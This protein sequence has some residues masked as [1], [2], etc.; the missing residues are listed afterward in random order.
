MKTAA[1]FAKKKGKLNET[2]LE[3][4]GFSAIPSGRMSQQLH[5][6]HFHRGQL[7]EHLDVL[8]SV[9]KPQRRTGAVLMIQGSFDNFAAITTCH[10]TITVHI[11]QYALE[12]AIFLT[13]VQDWISITIVIIWMLPSVGDLLYFPSLPI[14]FP[15]KKA[16]FTFHTGE[17]V[18]RAIQL[19]LFRAIF[20][21]KVQ[22]SLS[23]LCSCGITHMVSLN[24]NDGQWS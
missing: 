8:I 2:F 3:H 24:A 23:L 18:L 4:L 14:I 7:F 5:W 13:K 19:S 16:A 17:Y 12:Q 22:V 10:S 6:K 15:K 9:D 20:L 11:T 1:S 21:I